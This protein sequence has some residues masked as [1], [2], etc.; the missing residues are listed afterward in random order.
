MSGDDVEGTLRSIFSIRISSLSGS[1][2]LFEHIDEVR[3]A[4]G[5]SKN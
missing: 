3:A 4:D 2:R 5:L 1:T